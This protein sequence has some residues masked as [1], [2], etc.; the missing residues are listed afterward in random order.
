MELR[1]SLQAAEARES[2]SGDRETCLQ[3]VSKN[4]L[5]NAQLEGVLDKVEVKNADVQNMP[6]P[7][8]SF[9]V[10]LSNLCIHN[11]NAKAGRDLA[12]LEIA[13]VL[14]S[15]GKAIICDA[16][17]LNDYAEVFRNKGLTVT[18]LRGRFLENAMPW[19]KIL[20]ASK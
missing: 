20:V 5:N 17:Y 10:I 7:D 1:K 6:F 12:C 9:D 8:G 3:T 14:K 11:I 13:R 15:G 18:I 16:T 2:T 4:T 19:N